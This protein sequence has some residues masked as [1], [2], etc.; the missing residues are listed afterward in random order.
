[1]RIST[2]ATWLAAALCA[3]AACDEA[4]GDGEAVFT[5]WGE[6]YIEDEI[7]ADP[8]GEDGFVDG[9]RVEFDKFLVVFHAIEI[10]DAR[11]EIAAEMSGS[12]FVDNA[13]PG[14]KE[15]VVFRGVEAKHWDR[16]SFQIKPADAD[17]E[18]V[19]G[20]ADDLQ[21]MVDHGY[22]IYVAGSAEKRDENGD[23]I[24][25]TFRWGFTTATQ[26]E[27]CR[28]AEESGQAVEG[29]VITNGGRDTSELTTHGDHFFYDRLMASPDP[30][31]PTALRFEAMAAADADGDG[32][33]TLEEL[34]ETPIDVRLYDPSGLDAPS[35]GAFVTSLTRT[36]GHFRGEGECS[37]SVL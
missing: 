36:V 30:E 2:T 19:A 7:A 27:G 15:L 8:S 25:K 5:T 17:T 26:Y 3:L 1:M 31:L 10:A 37:I 29:I 23:T 13:V 28:Q 11:G 22:S 20:S 12:R 35:L 9:W 6:E 32:E 21:M 16:V 33:I 34:D 14:R 18:R 24:R 4:A